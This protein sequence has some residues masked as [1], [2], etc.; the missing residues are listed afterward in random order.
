[1]NWGPLKISH[2]HLASPH[3]DHIV[4]ALSCLLFGLECTDNAPLANWPPSRV[5]QIRRG[6]SIFSMPKIHPE[7]Y[8][9]GGNRENHAKVYLCTGLLISFRPEPPSSPQNALQM[10]RITENSWL[11]LSDPMAQ[12]L[13]LASV[14]L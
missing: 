4:A 11:S 6:L 8:N 9:R 14:W 12:C 7:I 5:F 10:H 3:L 13:G 2:L 1:M